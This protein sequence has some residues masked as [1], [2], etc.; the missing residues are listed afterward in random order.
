M[1]TPDDFYDGCGCGDDEEFR[2]HPWGCLCDDCNPPKCACPLCFCSDTVEFYGD[3][4][5]SCRSGAH[6][7]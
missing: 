3:R 5:A 7:G 1:P 6:Q 4:C 2:E